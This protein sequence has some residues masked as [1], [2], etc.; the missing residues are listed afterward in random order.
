MILLESFLPSSDSGI[1]PVSR[2]WFCHFQC[3][4]SMMPCFRGS[5]GRE[6]KASECREGTTVLNGL[7]LEVAHIV[8]SYVLLARTSYMALPRYKGAGKSSLQRAQEEHPTSVCHSDQNY[9][10]YVLP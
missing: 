10:H 9:V 4:A 2:L 1:Q 3:I 5:G 8:F 7:K 6:D